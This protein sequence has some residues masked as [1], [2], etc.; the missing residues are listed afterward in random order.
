MN[1]KKVLLITLTIVAIMASVSAVS[2]GWFDGLFGE[3]QHDNVIEIDNMTF[4]TT[5]ITKFELTNQTED[6]D[7]YRDGYMDENKTGY[8]VHIYNYSYANDIT[9]NA[10]I[11]YYTDSQ[12]G[13]LSSQTIDGVVVYTAVANTGD[14]VGEPRYVA[15][16][17][18]DDL[19]TIVD[20]WSPDSNETAKMASTLKFE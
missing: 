10:I 18:N 5:N 2:A 19:Q 15:Y 12:L 7:G 9:W 1:I 8:E 17:Q 11:Q 20:F 16:V 6:E 4:N 3:E 13:N 14:H